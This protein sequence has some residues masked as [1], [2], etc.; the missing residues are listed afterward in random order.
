MGMSLGVI[1]DSELDDFVSY[2][3]HEAA[4]LAEHLTKFDLIIGFNNK[5]FDN[6][7]LTPYTDINLNSLPAL[8]L[9][10]E[11]HNYLGYRLSLNGLSSETL[12]VKKSGDGLQALQW[13]KE[14]RIDLIR[15]YCKKDV[16][17]TKNLLL[18]GLEKGYLLFANKA[19]Q[20]V[21]LPLALDK[22][23]SRILS[24]SRKKMA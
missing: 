3:E 10:E 1:Y 22:S 9:L 2:L 8:D 18:H 23:I 6:L 24:A 12:G 4:Q 20:T 19:K 16:E 7:V 11:V 13:Y 17:L 14:G 5:R 21:R 15:H